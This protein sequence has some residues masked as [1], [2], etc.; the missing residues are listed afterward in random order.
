[1][2]WLAVLILFGVLFDTNVIAPLKAAK[3]EKERDN[4]RRNALSKKKWR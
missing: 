4:D 1:M 2:V 3:E